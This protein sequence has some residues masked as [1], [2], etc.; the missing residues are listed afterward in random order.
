MTISVMIDLETLGVSPGCVVLSVAAVAFDERGLSSLAP[1]PFYREIWQQSCLDAGLKY[2]PR[3]L[4]WWS[5]QPERGILARTAE[6]SH[7]EDG[8]NRL[9]RTLTDLAAWWED[10]ETKA[11]CYA[12]A[13]GNGA[14]FDLPILAACFHAKQL[15]APWRPYAGRCYRTLKNL[16][17][18]MKIGD[19]PGNEAPATAHHA[20]DDATRQARHCAELL[21]FLNTMTGVK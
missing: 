6:H 8:A 2:D 10:L 13:Y 12:L 15:G 5:Q 11:G 3:T 19:A 7:G 21:R 16:V 20:L 17:P 18:T 14:D 1:R 4:A 9:H